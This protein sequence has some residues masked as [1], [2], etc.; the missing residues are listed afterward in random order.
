M[1][2]FK[3]VAYVVDEVMA[4]REHFRVR[5]QASAQWADNDIFENIVAQYVQAAATLESSRDRASEN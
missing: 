1:T 5:L 2:D 4:L 3:S